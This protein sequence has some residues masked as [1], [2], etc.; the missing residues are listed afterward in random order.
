MENGSVTR[1]SLADIYFT[2]IALPDG[3]AAVLMDEVLEESS[4]LRERR[5]TAAEFFGLYKQLQEY[6]KGKRQ[7]FELPLQVYGTPFQVKVWNQLAK[8]PY[9]K[10]VSYKQIAQKIKQPAATRA[11]GNANGRNPVPIVIP[12]HR[13]IA[14]DGKLGGYSAGL[15]IKQR[16]LDLERKY[17]AKK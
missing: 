10:T 11:V 9:G 12:C 3:L 5:P 13:V 8:I 4:Y 6:F 7:Q 16:L 2:A 17:S 1:F 14:T 15:E